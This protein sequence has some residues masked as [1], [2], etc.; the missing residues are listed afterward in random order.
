[1]ILA[2]IRFDDINR[3][4]NIQNKHQTC[5][6]RSWSHHPLMDVV[7]VQRRGWDTPIVAI[8]HLND[9]PEIGEKTQTWPSSKTM[10]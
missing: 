7:E 6:P 2:I 9:P 3:I 10:N 8:H 5:G 4:W 1:M